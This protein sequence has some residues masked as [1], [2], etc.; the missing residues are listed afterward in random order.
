MRSSRSPTRQLGEEVLDTDVSSAIPKV[1]RKNIDQVPK[2]VTRTLE[3]ILR[4]L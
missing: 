4:R 3:N 2:L 1:G